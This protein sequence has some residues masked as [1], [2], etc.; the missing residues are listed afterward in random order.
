MRYFGST[1]CMTMPNGFKPILTPDFE[2]HW[3]PHD[4]LLYN[5]VE[6]PLEKLPEHEMSW[7]A[8]AYAY[9]VERVNYW[10]EIFDL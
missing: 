9:G 2:E 1:G 10:N 5:G 8:A 6:Q 3:E 4:T 7:F